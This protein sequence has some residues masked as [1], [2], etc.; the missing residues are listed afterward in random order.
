MPSKVIKRGKHW[1]YRI[2][3]PDE[4]GNMKWTMRAGGRTKREAEKAYYKAAE[5]IENEGG[6]YD[7]ERITVKQFL[8]TWFTDYVELNLRDATIKSYKSDLKNHI[9]PALGKY[10]LGK[11]NSRIIQKFIN[12]KSDY[13]YGT[14]SHML[15]VLKAA[16]SYAIS[17]CGYIL[18]N[19]TA[20]VRVPKNTKPP[21]K[22]C[23]FSKID[24]EKIWQKFPEGHHYYLPIMIAYHTGLRVGEVLG[25]HWS[26]IDLNADELTV[27]GTM[28]ESGVYQPY[29]KT[30]DSCRTIP[31]GHKLNLI[32]KKEKKHQAEMK[33]RFSHVYNSNNYVC[34]RENGLRISTGDM[35]YFNEWTKETF[36]DGY[37]FHSLR[38]THATMLLE[39][40]E[41]LELVSK[42]LGHSNIVTTS[43]IYSHIMRDR[44]EKTLRLLNSVL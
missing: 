27:R 8:E 44:K 16:F 3:V 43:K 23:V 1:Y 18:T 30:K 13:S 28:T 20:G 41:S 37:T 25:L 14:I 10:H 35:R 31:F 32:L 39:A 38:H 15:T 33:L 19:P 4:N 12:T 22:T 17:P 34:C 7:A 21:R 40:G 36:G 2:Q 6:I 11:I 24:I 29:P 5:T 9:V 42:R 26:D